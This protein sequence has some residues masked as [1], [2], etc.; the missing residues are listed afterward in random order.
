MKEKKTLDPRWLTV[1]QDGPY[2]RNSLLQQQ[3]L[4][5]VLPREIRGRSA[6]VSL[7]PSKKVV[8]GNA[9]QE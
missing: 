1:Y 7:L 9:G 5:K 4:M 6:D 8:D 3:A 2:Q